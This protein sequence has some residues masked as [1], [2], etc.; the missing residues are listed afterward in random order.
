MCGL[1]LVLTNKRPEKFMFSW[2]DCQGRVPLEHPH[3][4]GSANQAISMLTM[5]CAGSRPDMLGLCWGYMGIM[6]KMETMI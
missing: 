2:W 6:E 3:C 1:G 5:P 4:N